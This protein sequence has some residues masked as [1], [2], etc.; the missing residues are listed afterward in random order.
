ML[1]YQQPA[2]SNQQPATSNQQPATSNQQPA[3]SNQQWIFFEK[4]YILTPRYNQKRSM[5]KQSWRLISRLEKIGDFIILICAFL[6]AYYGR[7][8]F[9]FWNEFF[10]APLHFS[11]KDLAPLREYSVVLIVAILSQSVF[12][13]LLGAYSSMRLRS[14][15][16]IFKVFVINAFLIFVVLSA[17]MF[18]LKLDLSRSFV[19]LFCILLVFFLVIER[20]VVMWFLRSARKNGFNYRSVIICGIG[21]QALSI[22]K[23]IAARPELGLF[24]RCYVDLSNNK[25]DPQQKRAFL[26]LVRRYPRMQSVRIINSVKRLSKA[27]NEYAVDEVIFADSLN[28]MPETREVIQLCF[29]QGIQTTLVADVFSIGILKSG[30]SYFDGLPLVHYVTPPGD[31]WAL[32]LKRCFDIFCSLLLLIVLF[33]FLILIA[34]AVKF[35]S[36]GPIFY[37]QKRVG[38]N[39]HLFNFYKF[40]SMVV[41]ADKELSEL[42]EQNEME[43]PAFKMKNDPRVTPLGRF[44]RKH[45]LDELPQLWNV[46]K[47]DMSLV[48]PRPPVPDEVRYYERKYRRRLSMRPGMTCTWQVSGRNE[49]SEFSKWVELDLDYIDNWSLSRD[50]VILFETIPAVLF[51]RGAS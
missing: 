40:R 7:T 14:P 26:E 6:L 29:E 2:T 9:I 42:K 35:T 13:N 17:T 48:G 31:P 36:K 32:T 21:P 27:L 1:L 43:G 10:N 51:G 22:T 45:S 5:L 11:G 24:I 39:G 30:L 47:G 12:L 16:Q 25:T 8:S 46:L 38:L 34:L 15:G 3:T 19:T 50:I 23:R 33:P 4:F 49:I 18:L 20:Y 37:V 41:D 44:L 28:V